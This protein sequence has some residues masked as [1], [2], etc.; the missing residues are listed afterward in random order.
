MAR[1]FR[2]IRLLSLLSLLPLC[3]CSHGPVGNNGSA[4]WDPESPYPLPS[5][6]KV[7]EIVHLPTG[8]LVSMDQMLSIA[9]DYR[10]VY[11]GETHD[12]PAS[13]R[14]ELDFLKGME[15]RHPGR[16]AVGMEMFV[17][18]Q[19]PVLDRWVAGELTEKEF[20]KQVKWYETWRSDFAYYREILFYARDHKIPVVA[21]NAEKS[22]VTALRTKTPEELP[23]QQRLELP[24]M[25][26][27]DPYQRALISAIF[28]DHLKGGLKIDGFVRAQT[29]WDETMAESVANFL[30]SPQGKDRH[31]LVFAGGHHVGYGFGIPRR[32]FRRMPA[33][34]LL[35]GGHEINLGAEKQDRLMDVEIPQFPMVPYDFLAYL[36]YEDLPATGV[37]LGVVLE[38]ASGGKGVLV[39]MVEPHSAADAAGIQK[40]DVILEIDGT[41][42]AENFDL[43]YVVQQKHPGDRGVLKIKRQEEIL[44]L[45]AT[46]AAP[47]T[48]LHPKK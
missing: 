2:S 1:L 6:P 12:N 24:Q 27:N 5:P 22:L 28:S 44:T 38:P 45:T 34:Y 19:Q 29:L 40:G 36:K 17:R 11:V 33:S 37:R 8:K 48:D 25:D 3:A 35:V 16:Q 7:G 13:H 39:T 46:F 9:A 21:L 32:V 26:F 43:V 31:L 41:P 18:S 47:A 30:D 23:P 10:I 20:L 15:E 4:K 42:I 14:L